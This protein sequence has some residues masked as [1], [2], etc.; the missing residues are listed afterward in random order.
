VNELPAGPPIKCARCEEGKSRG[1]YVHRVWFCTECLLAIERLRVTQTEADRDHWKELADI[2][3][4]AT[5]KLMEIVKLE[6]EQA[7]QLLDK[8]M[9]RER[10]NEWK[11]AIQAAIDEFKAPGSSTEKLARLLTE[12]V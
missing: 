2:Y 10:E 11:D 4:R 7:G 1:V 3:D 6:R 12:W 8:I 5:D 9:T